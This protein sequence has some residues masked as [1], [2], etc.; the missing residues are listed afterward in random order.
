MGQPCIP[1][2][3]MGDAYYQLLPLSMALDNQEPLSKI[4]PTVSM[5]HML[6]YTKENKKN[7]S[8]PT[9]GSSNP[10][11]VQEILIVLLLL[12]ARLE[13]S[14]IL[15]LWE[16]PTYPSYGGYWWCVFFSLSILVD[17]SCLWKS[18]IYGPSKSVYRAQFFKQ[19]YDLFSLCDHWLSGDDF[20]IIPWSNENSTLFYLLK[21][22][23]FRSFYRQFQPLRDFPLLTGFTWS[24]S[25]GGASTT[26]KLTD[27]YSQ[28]KS[29]FSIHLLWSKG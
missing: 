2:D 18:G 19:L 20:N 4:S 12:V 25:S 13:A 16:W 28:K 1:Y 17:D 21:Y 11:W 24:H 10:F 14:G 22:E 15:T 7:K 3:T 6:F 29:S 26:L 9:E 8:M 27:S 23:A 5:T